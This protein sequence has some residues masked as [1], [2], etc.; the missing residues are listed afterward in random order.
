VKTSAS[1]KLYC[2][3]VGLVQDDEL[4]LV[5]FVCNANPLSDSPRKGDLTPGRLVERGPGARD[6]WE[7]T[8]DGTVD[9]TDVIAFLRAAV[10]V[11]DLEAAP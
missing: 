2:P 6:G 5:S 10:G 1:E 4:E 7:G 11:H 9:I 8:E 3:G